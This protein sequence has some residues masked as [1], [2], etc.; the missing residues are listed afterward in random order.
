M[1]GKYAIPEKKFANARWIVKSERRDGRQRTNAR[2]SDYFFQPDK[3]LDS[4]R[5][6]FYYLG[7]PSR[8]GRAICL[9]RLLPGRESWIRAD[10][11]SASGFG[12]LAA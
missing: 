9:R 5:T 8:F 6:F 3:S 11:S 2:G 12:S 4:E 7:S 10:I 1:Q